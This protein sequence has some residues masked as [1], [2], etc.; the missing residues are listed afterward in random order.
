MKVR[1]RKIFKI[2]TST[3][4]FVSFALLLFVL[5]TNSKKIRHRVT[6]QKMQITILDS[7]YLGFVNKQDIKKLIDKEYGIYLGQRLDSV[8]LRKIETILK[9]KTSILSGEAYTTMDGILHIVISQREPAIRF[10]TKDGGYYADEKGYIFPLHPAYKAPVRVIEGN[11]P[12]DVP[13]GYKGRAKTEAE[14][15]WLCG[16][17]ELTRYIE[18]DDYW[19][20]GIRE[21]LVENNGDLVL[22]PYSGK[23]KFVFGKPENVE[24]KFRKIEDYYKYI[25]PSKEEGYYSYVNVKY[26]GQIICRIKE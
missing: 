18:A 6:C 22:K 5:N 15:K 8:N 10:K 11:I 17:I 21:I 13:E 14:Q 26:D 20:K 7:A 24:K 12:L 16:A 9:K 25:V 19:E 23:E 3:L 4:I 2:A 1:W